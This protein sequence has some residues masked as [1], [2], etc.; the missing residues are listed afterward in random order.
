MCPLQSPN[1]QRLQTFC[2]PGTI[3][4]SFLSGA[5]FGFFIGFP[6]TVAVRPLSLSLSPTQ[7]SFFYLVLISS[8]DVDA[9]SFQL[10]LAIRADWSAF[11]TTFHPGP[12]QV[13]PER[14]MPPSIC[15]ANLI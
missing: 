15:D 7:P 10:L 5:L 1:S 6:L 2:I 14:S 13:V 4:L 3:F 8:L 9:G 12:P 11:S